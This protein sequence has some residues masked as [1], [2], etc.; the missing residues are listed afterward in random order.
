MIL[1][2]PALHN[3]RPR[4]T[5]KPPHTSSVSESRQNASHPP[6]HKLTETRSQPTLRADGPRARRRHRA[7]AAWQLLA[8]RSRA[9]ARTARRRE[10]RRRRQLIARRRS[11]RRRHPSQR[12]A[13]RPS[14]RARR[15]GRAPNAGWATLDWRIR[16]RPVGAARRRRRAHRA[17][18]VGRAARRADASLHLWRRACRPL[19]RRAAR[20]AARQRRRRTERSA[21]GSVRIEVGVLGGDEAV[22]ADWAHAAVR[23][24]AR[25]AAAAPIG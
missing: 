2:I 19:H 20:R 5:N 9:R 21:G 17:A 6:T 22:I 11:G 8:A 1:N 18:A 14:A 25:D 15:A 10:P 13:S 7:W 23:C 16:Q 4:P 12:H 3:S 24:E